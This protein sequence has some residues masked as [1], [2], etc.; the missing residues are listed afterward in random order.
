MDI[1]TSCAEEALHQEFVK[2]K[3]E[4]QNKQLQIAAYPYPE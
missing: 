2:K 1:D 3:K 4:L